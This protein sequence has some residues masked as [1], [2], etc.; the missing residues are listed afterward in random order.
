[1]L[2]TFNDGRLF[3]DAPNPG[4][5][6][7][8]FLH[9][10]SRSH[11]D[12]QALIAKLPAEA[13]VINFD[14]PG[15]GASPE[16][17]E[18]WGANE[19]GD[20]IAAALKDQLEGGGAIFFGHSFGGRVT[21]ALSLRHPEL[22]RG[23]VLC[24]SP[25]LIASDTNAERASKLKKPKTIYLVVRWLHK[26]GWA[27]DYRIETLRQKYGS[28]DYKAAVGVMRGV[29]TKLVN[30]TYTSEVEALR[31]PVAMVWGSNDTEAPADVAR[32]AD[33][34]FARNGLI[35]RLEVIEGADHFVYRSHPESI[36]GAIVFVEL[37]VAGSLHAVDRNIGNAS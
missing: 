33:E 24:G 32:A 15:F 2:R 4:P 1:M 37:A 29:L 30:E 11:K 27:S 31:V 13:R 34:V 14:L 10:W 26:H 21:M 28:R 22:V 20:S 25:S 6:T 5:Y 36:V 9:G 19:Y 35:H 18:A 7:H 23:V 12:F 8:V 16:P 17:P 3:G